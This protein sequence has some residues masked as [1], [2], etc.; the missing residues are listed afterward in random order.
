MCVCTHMYVLVCVCGGGGG[1]GQT[2]DD[3]FVY[4]NILC[5]CQRFLCFLT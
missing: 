3:K 2:F 5:L 1:G 4:V